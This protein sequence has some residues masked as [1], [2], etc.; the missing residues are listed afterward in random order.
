DLHGILKQALRAS[1]ERY[2]LKDLEVFFGFQR[3]TDLREA[4]KA[5][6]NLECALELNEVA[7]IPD[8]VPRTV[9]AYNREDC[10]STL[11]L[12]DW[13]ERIRRD[14]VVNGSEI[15]RPPLEP[16]DPTE[17]IDERRK[18]TL[19]LMERLLQGV[20]E[21]PSERTRDQHAKWLLAHLLEWHR[22]E[23]KAPWWEFFR[24]RALSDEELLEERCAIA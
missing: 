5:L 11:R 10:I 20:P 19:A 3:T 16:G 12:R 8:E 4:K 18:R 15:K 17:A 14:L 23:E 6:R 9:E 21:Q 24:L 2:S 22:R 1:V 13:L 7:G